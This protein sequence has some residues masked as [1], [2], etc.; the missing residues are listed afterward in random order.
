MAETLY[1]IVHEFVL[2]HGPINSDPS[3]TLPLIHRLV[4]FY[5]TGLAEDSLHEQGKR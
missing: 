2:N 4:Q 5:H 1:S 3:P